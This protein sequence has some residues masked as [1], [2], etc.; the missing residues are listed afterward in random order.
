M[1]EAQ[2][3]P[4]RDGE[5]L[6]LSGF[7]IAKGKTRFSVTNDKRL[8]TDRELAY[9]DHGEGTFSYRVKGLQMVEIGGELVGVFVLEVL[10]AEL[11]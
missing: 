3:V 7:P 9:N 11:A 10:S 4:I 1:S 6:I 8:V 5:Q 2:V